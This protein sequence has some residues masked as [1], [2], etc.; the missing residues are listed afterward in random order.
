MQDIPI[1]EALAR[2]FAAEDVDTHFTLM[3]QHALD[4]LRR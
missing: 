4:R 2:A 1:C 3:G